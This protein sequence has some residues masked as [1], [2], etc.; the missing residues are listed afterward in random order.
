M[1]FFKLLIIIYTVIIKSILY[2]INMYLLTTV[3]GYAV[4]R[5]LASRAKQSAPGRDRCAL[6]GYTSR[7]AGR[8][9]RTEGRSRISTRRGREI[10]GSTRAQRD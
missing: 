7:V 2:R 1:I 6:V 9:Q 4:R 10:A 3:A 5:L 8:G